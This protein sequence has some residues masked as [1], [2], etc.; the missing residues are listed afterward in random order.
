MR[1]VVRAALSFLLALWT[2]LAFAKAPSVKITAAQARQIALAKVPGELIRDEL[3]RE[4]GRWIYSIEI[5]P[6]G[7]T[8]K[9]VMEVNI[10]AD[11]GAVLEISVERN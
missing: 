5:R 11:S 9:R 7:E 8:R 10:D 1:N 3:E 4:K 6:I 2:T